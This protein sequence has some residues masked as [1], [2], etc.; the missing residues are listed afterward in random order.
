MILR[1]LNRNSEPQASIE[2]GPYTLQYVFYLPVPTGFVQFEIY[3]G[4]PMRLESANFGE[5]AGIVYLVKAHLVIGNGATASL[6]LIQRSSTPFS[7]LGPI[8]HIMPAYYTFWSASV[9]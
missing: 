8:R 6:E 7:I 9:E 3:S 5:P 4:G 1:R 2:S